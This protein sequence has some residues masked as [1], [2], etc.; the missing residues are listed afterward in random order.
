M[1]SDIC[2]FCT[3]AEDSFFWFG[4]V[5]VEAQCIGSMD[6]N[7]KPLAESNV[8]PNAAD[9]PLQLGDSFNNFFKFTDLSSLCNAK[10]TCAVKPQGC[11]SDAYTGKLVITAVDSNLPLSVSAE[12]S[13]YASAPWTETVCVECKIDQ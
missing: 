12:A 11:T 2:V 1:S 8:S 6:K 5:D 9:T 7:D 4:K 10:K 13:K 3:T